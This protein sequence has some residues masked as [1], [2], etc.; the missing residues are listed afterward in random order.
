MTRCHR[1]GLAV[2]NGL[3]GGEVVA[4][5]IGRGEEWFVVFPD[6]EAT[7]AAAALL[8]GDSTRTLCYPSKR[9]WLI[10][11]W[12]DGDITFAEAGNSWVAIIGCS[13]ISAPELARIMQR[14]GDVAALDRLALTLPG[15][16]H[17]V[18]SVNGRQRVQGSA[19]GL[20]RVF[21][22]Q[23]Q[24]MTVGADRAD[25][26]ARLC[27]AAVDERW[28]AVRLLYPGPPYPLE[29]VLPWRAVEAVTPGHYL[30]VE[31]DGRSRPV[32][33]WRP[34][35]P[36]VPLAEGAVVLREALST[37]V[38]ARTSSGGTIS[39]D[40]SGGLDSTPICYLATSHGAKPIL[41]TVVGLDPGD[42]DEIWADWAAQ[43]LPG[44]ERE[45]L[46]ADQVPS[47]FAG[48]L[49]ADVPLDEPLSTAPFWTYY[50]WIARHLAA[51]GSRL[52]LNG[53]GGDELFASSPTAF[54]GTLIRTDPRLGWQHARA[55][56]ALYRWSMQEV[57]RVWIDRCSYQACLA[58]RAGTITDP[59]PTG[60][61]PETWVSSCRMP[62][63]TTP[64]AV[65]VVR[66]MMREAAATTE[67]IAPTRGQHNDLEILRG[68]AYLERLVGQVSARAGLR[69]ASPYYDDR[70][71]EASLAV[72]P[73]ERITP[74]QYK[75]LIVEAMR[76]VVPDAS[77]QRTTKA[78]TSLEVAMGMRR[79]RADLLALC[80][81]SY[82]ARLGLVDSDK[83]RAS[84]HS[85]YQSDVAAGLS[86]TL[87]CE[88]WLRAVE[89]WFCATPAISRPVS[90]S[91]M[92]SR[93]DVSTG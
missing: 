92:E 31:R 35:E 22:T 82:L 68:G 47:P 37:A 42:D 85:M 79:H 10:G 48:L 69:T 13:P 81:D 11:N 73:H 39:A 19:S 23:L 67:P 83:L 2:N 87:G 30:L 65:E 64:Q 18:A 63:W 51:R 60:N 57:V 80:E 34:P 40:L 7:L 43:G 88:L 75:P 72:R 76:G 44:L 3:F 49:T 6:C 70:V 38:A 74:W 27:R 59:R 9:P 17:L 41:C 89:R 36:S 8:Q 78:D 56:R 91:V 1:R 62:S 33:W 26:L 53:Q 52:H 32:R 45:V 66:E 12:S 77:L 46:L 93:H 21:F 4:G 61:P 58:D 29:E 16:F 50:D 54:L 15:S 71:V 84:C 5:G 24:G 86:T 28:L 25:T 55:Y 20:R 14:A 90:E